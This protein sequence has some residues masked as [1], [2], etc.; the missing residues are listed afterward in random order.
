MSKI[1]QE[2]LKLVGSLR[3]T[4]KQ[5]SDLKRDRAETAA[6]LYE[7]FLKDYVFQLNCSKKDA[8]EGL[9]RFF[10]KS[11]IKIAAIDGTRYERSRRGCVAFYVLA[12]PL[13]YELDLDAKD[14]RPRR[15]EEETLKHNIMA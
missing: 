3:D 9:K 14:L 7:T 11:K 13:I 6:R 2:D 10:N 12:A 5:F 8:A 15:L 1:V 4:A